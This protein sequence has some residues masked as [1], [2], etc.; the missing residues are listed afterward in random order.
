MKQTTLIPCLLF[1]GQIAFGQSAFQPQQQVEVDII[2]AGAP[3][4]AIWKSGLVLKIEGNSVS[5]QLDD[6]REMSIP[7]T[8]N[9]WLRPS[10]QAKATPSPT[11]TQVSPPKP[12]TP[13]AKPVGTTKGRPALGAPPDGTY[14]CE[15]ISG[16]MLI[17]L[18]KLVIRGGTYQ[19]LAG[20]NFSPFTVSGEG[21]ITFSVGLTGF[22]DGATLGEAKYVGN[23]HQGHPLI[24]IFYRTPSGWKDQIDAV[25][26]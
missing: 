18:G 15:K 14:E 19:G 6:G 8:G 22:P 11:V 25:M 2:M 10:T 5:V 4:R 23:D 13:P 21:M 17:S 9:R 24:Y 7:V 3:E 20:G 12:S 1:L 26:R 16:S